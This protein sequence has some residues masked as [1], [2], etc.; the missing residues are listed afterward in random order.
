MPIVF[1]PSFEAL[2]LVPF[3]INP[4]YLDHDPKSTHKVS[5]FY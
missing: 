4:H 1:P 5:F 2:S 3:N